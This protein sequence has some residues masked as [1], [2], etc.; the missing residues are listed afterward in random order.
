ME[1]KNANVLGRPI[2]P[3]KIRRQN[4]RTTLCQLSRRSI[5]WRCN[6]SRVRQ[7][8][9]LCATHPRRQR[10]ICVHR[11]RIWRKLFLFVFETSPVMHRFS[12]FRTAQ[13]RSTSTWHSKTT[14]NMSKTRKQSRKRSQIP[15]QSL[16]L[17]S[18][19][20]KQSKSI[21]RLRWVSS[22][23]F[24]DHSWWGSFLEK[25]RQWFSIENGEESWRA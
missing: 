24:R 3:H 15:S 8:S 14:L 1:R 5:S 2:D 9:L 21:W 12:S 4:V 23:S 25:G 13:T 18:R 19:K 6:W 11:N 22:E 10:T 16:T 17:G 20:A 7:L